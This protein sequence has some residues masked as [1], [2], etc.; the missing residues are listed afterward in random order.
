MLLFLSNVNFYFP[1]SKSA[2]VIVQSWSF[3]FLCALCH[4]ITGHVLASVL[5]ISYRFPFCPWISILSVLLFS[6][7]ISP[8]LNL[9]LIFLFFILTWNTNYFITQIFCFAK[10]IL[11]QTPYWYKYS[12]HFYSILSSQ[13]I[14]N[15]LLVSF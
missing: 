4:G 1:S 6:G 8:Y 9:F 14:Q 11:I 15:E 12:V 10:E 5:W 2:H 13:S 3:L 7:S